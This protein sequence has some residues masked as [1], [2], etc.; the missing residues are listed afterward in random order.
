MI[1]GI[2]ITTL[3]ENTASGRDTLGEHGLS[4]WIDTGDH[5]ILFD[6]GQT[7][8]VLRHNAGRLGVNL[9]SVE[10][11]VLSH[12]HYDHTGGLADV[13]KQSHRPKLYLHPAAL[14]RRF[15]RHRDG[16]VQDV[17]IPSSL[18]IQTLEELADPVWTDQPTQIVPGLFVTGHIPRLTDYE[19]TGGDFHL[20]DTCSRPDPIADDQAVYFDT[21]AGLVVLLGCAHAGL[22]NTLGHIGRTIGQRPIHAVIGGMH[23]VHASPDRMNRTVS[24]LRQLDVQRLAPT[25]CTGARAAARLWSEFPESWQPCPVGTTF[26]FEGAPSL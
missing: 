24:A 25:H 5:R 22:I 10:A 21:P 6:T 9:A 2:R 12:G 14:Q 4:F 26:E 8:A 18:D 20:D 3:V 1:N 7:P 15:S 19:D 23:L 17:G 16:S 11:I 13:L